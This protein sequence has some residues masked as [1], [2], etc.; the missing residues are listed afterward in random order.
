MKND[1]VWAKT[2][3]SVYRYLERICDAI[4][5][6]V[7]KSALGS[8][9][10]VGQDYSFNNVYS[11]SQKIIDY[12]ERKITLINLK[13][14][15][16]DILKEIAPNDAKILIERYVEGIK[17]REMAEKFDIGLRTVYRKI[18]HA[19]QAFVKKMRFKGYDAFKMQE[20]L[21]NELWIKNAYL[22]IENNGD[23]GFQISGVGLK[24]AVSM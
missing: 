19:E 14:L 7:M 20:W 23:E 17:R 12:S 4:D 1:M 6:I 18:D 24:K 9:N 5:N 2:I 15:I 22:A 13:I 10:I 3:L 11:I 21:K 8:Y 16:E